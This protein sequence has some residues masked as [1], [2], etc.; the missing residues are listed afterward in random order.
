MV[1]SGNTSLSA[2]SIAYDVKVAPASLSPWYPGRTNFVDSFKLIS[3]SHGRGP[4]TNGD[5]GGAFYLNK[6]H[7]SG[8][9]GVGAS[10]Y[11]RGQ[12]MVG[13]PASWVTPGMPAEKT[14]TQLDALGTSAIARSAPTNPSFDAATFIGELRQSG[15]P[16]GYGSSLYHEVAL[17]HDLEERT[18]LARAA[19]SEYLNVEFGWKPLVRDLQKFATAV[20]DSHDIIS[21]YH[22]GSGKKIRRRYVYPPVTTTYQDS[23][24]GFLPIPDEVYETGTGTISVIVKEKT[25]FSGAFR[26]YLPIADDA[27]GR[28]KLYKSY[29]N[30]LFGVS[31]TPEAVWNVSPWSWAADW[32]GTTGDVLHNISALGT[33]GLVLQYGYIMRQVEREESRI[34]RFPTY[35][36]S[37]YSKY[38]KTC[39]RRPATPYGFGVSLDSL[40]AKQTAILVALGLSHQGKA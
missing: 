20:R 18:K 10:N 35:G 27:I 29:A 37:S 24:T 1:Q 11:H 3:E 4:Y 13:T 7:H 40:S 26:Y 15:L 14:N 38:E 34:A 19:G 9:P 16:S 31:L 28:L 39:V 21:S 36:P 12:F 30:K 32:F 17:A 33:D 8:T 2:A 5:Q 23:R 25:W 6:V 22:K